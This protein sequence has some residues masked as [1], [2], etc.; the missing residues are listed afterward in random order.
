MQTFNVLLK[1]VREK[2]T[3][4]KKVCKTL[5]CGNESLAAVKKAL[6]SFARMDWNDSVCEYLNIGAAMKKK[7]WHVNEKNYITVR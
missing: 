2:G 3:M 5:S 4:W 7:N 6:T 1:N